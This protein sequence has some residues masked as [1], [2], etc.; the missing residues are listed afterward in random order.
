MKDE[1]VGVGI[2][3]K[4]DFKAI[5][6]EN[7]ELVYKMAVKYT[8][9]HHMA[10]D[11]VQEVFLKLY[12]NVGSVKKELIRGW[13]LLTAKNMSLNLKRDHRREYLTEETDAEAEKQL[14]NFVETPEEFLMREMKEH[15]FVILKKGIFDALYKKNIRW[16]EAITMT[17]VLEKPQ[18]EVAES[19]G[20]TVEVLHS[21][22]YRAKQ[23]IRENYAEEYK[24]LN[25]I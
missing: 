24:R 5:Y 18:K 25:N 10:E 6:D 3:T 15:Q 22:L 17:Y 8:G 16:Y 21:I 23:W 13:L 4:T 19:I 20:V 1:Y 11:I 2:I 7:F 14:S 12:L 9:N